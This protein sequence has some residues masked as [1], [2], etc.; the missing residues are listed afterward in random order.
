M[1][2]GVKNLL[3]LLAAVAVSSCANRSV[4]SSVGKTIPI[5]SPE[6]SDSLAKSAKQPWTSGNRITT[7]ENG[8]AFYPPMLRAIREAKNTITFEAFA[9]VPGTVA[10]DFTVALC[11]RAKGGVKVHLILDAIGSAKL[12]KSHLKPMRA[13]GV[14]VHLYHPISS[15]RLNRRTHRKIL[16]T[17]GNLAFTGG[18]G[19]ADSWK[20][21]ACNGQ[22]WRD[23]M[24]QIQG[25][26]VAQLQTTFNENWNR[27]TS[28][29]LTGPTYFPSLKKKG[30]LQAAFVPDSPSDDRNPIAHSVL[31]AINSTQ[32]ALLLE[33]SYFVPNATFRKALIRAAARG[34]NITLI[35]PGPLIDSAPTRH[36]SQNHW[37]DYLDAGI[38]L[39]Q[40]EGSMLHGK[41]LIA[42]QKLTII[43]S[44]NL[45]ARSFF[46]ND[47]VNLHVLS[48]RF[49]RKQTEMFLRDLKRSRRITKGNLKEVLAPLPKR[50][51]AEAIAPQL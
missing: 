23:T 3:G 11:E 45:D 50:I 43:G 48:E 14:Q 47:E 22:Q 10:N 16:I 29:S 38:G 19:F 25:P 44:G 5:S 27:L 30:T 51:L 26:A 31:H 17:D 46:L 33:Q 42:D 13:C 9:Y 8:D 15:L 6:F 32:R 20:G 28:E 41:L 35:V 36:A 39:H 24:Y 21:D 34:V 7:F 12:G 49:A 18:A 1:R 37:G 4:D 40:F 2:A